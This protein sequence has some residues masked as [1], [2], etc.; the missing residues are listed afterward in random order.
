MPTP[1]SR[2]ATPPT[3]DQRALAHHIWRT[4]RDTGE[5]D[6]ALESRPESLL[7]RVALESRPESLLRRGLVRVSTSAERPL[8]PGR[9]G[10][11]GNPARYALTDAGLEVALAEESVRA[12]RIAVHRAN[13]GH[14][15]MIG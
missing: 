2:P 11:K 15:A 3:A 1:T 14:N 8:K 9:V 7:R 10:R 13:R 5:N 6:V 4:C 12:E